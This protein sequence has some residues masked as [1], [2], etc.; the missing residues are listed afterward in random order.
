MIIVTDKDKEHIK[1]NKK[2][3]KSVFIGFFHFALSG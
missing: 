2:A 3:F 1:T